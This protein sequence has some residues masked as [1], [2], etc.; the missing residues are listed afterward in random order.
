MRFL[1]Q[2]LID[3]RAG[4]L[5]H[6]FDLR[7]VGGCVRDHLMGMAPKDVDLCTDATPAEQVMVYGALRLRHVPTGIDHGTITVVLSGVPYE[8]TSL[9]TED[10]HDGRH[11][12]VAFT[13]DW[14]EDLSRRDLTVNA[15]AL[16]FDGDLLD[17][18]GGKADL[19]QRRVR[20]VGDPVA[21]MRE[22]YLR[23]LR[24][25]RFHGR[26]AGYADLDAETLR[27]VEQEA[28]GLERI[29]RERVW[30]EMQK[31]APGPAGDAMLDAIVT[32]GVAR[33][34]DLPDDWREDA[35][36][37]HARLRHPVTLLT[38][39]LGSEVLGLARAWKWSNEE[40]AL[41]RYLVE[42][43]ADSL[44]ALK[45]E[46]ALRNVPVDRVVQLALLREMPDHAAMLAAWQPPPFPVG[47]QD[48]LALGMKPGPAL[49]Q[50][51]RALKEAWAASHYTLTREE[52]L[53]R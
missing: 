37:A 39:L 17:P 32:S 36:L 19:E 6:G 43:D 15:M 5:H 28:A 35:A 7:L 50:A 8:I 31:I 14:H 1:T 48:L 44:A 12:R 3:L 33:H 4:F 29:S 13:R 23:I 20:F 24:W 2:D 11:A 16:T 45:A 53:A 9:R 18:F 22:D 30:M 41:A 42:S 34:I 52:L 47:G 51:L 40:L 25:F 21:R 49:G 26:I 38:A 27:A 46:V 10:E